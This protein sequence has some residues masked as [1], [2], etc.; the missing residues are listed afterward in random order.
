MTSQILKSLSSKRE[1][2]VNHIVKSKISS[3][4]ASQV[5]RMAGVVDVIDDILSDEFYELVN[6]QEEEVK[7]AV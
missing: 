7:D 6:E 3:E 2:L 5:S 4:T 1:E